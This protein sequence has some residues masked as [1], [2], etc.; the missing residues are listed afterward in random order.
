MQALLEENLILRFLFVFLLAV[1][2]IKFWK[3]VAYKLNLVDKPDHR[4]RM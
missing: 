2:L 3:Q 4:K 1:V